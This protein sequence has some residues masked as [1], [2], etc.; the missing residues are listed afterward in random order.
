MTSRLRGLCTA[1][2]F[3]TVSFAQAP[4]IQAPGGGSIQLDTSPGDRVKVTT[5]Y[6]HLEFDLRNGG[7][8]DT[9]VFKHGSGNNLLLAP[10]RTYVDRWCAA[11]APKT[12]FRP[13]RN[14]DIVTLEFSGRMA[15]AGR[16]P[17]PVEF[18]TTWTLSP[19]V[20]RADYKLRFLEDAM[21]S[22][23]GVVSTSLRRELNEWGLRVG[24]T[25]DPDRRK[26][27]GGRF[28]KVQQAG[29]VLIAEHH[30]PTYM[31][32]FDRAKEGFDITVA[33]DVA[34]WETGLA[35]R[36]GVGR[37][38]AK[39]ADDGGSISLAME[40]LSLPYP[41]KVAKGE[42][43]FSYYLGLPRIVEKAN[44][45]W[46]HLSF[47]NHPWPSDTEVKKWAD[48][49]VNIVRLHNDYAEDENFWH[50][51]AWPPYDDK[52]M[53]EMKRVI[54]ACHRHNIQVVPYFSIHE[55]HP[56][57][58]GY[59]ANENEW[60]R[61]VDQAG[62][63]FHNAW[64]KGEFGAQMCPQSRWLERRKQDI[65]RAYRDLGFDGIYYDWVMTLPCTNKAHNEKLHLG[66]DGVID[67]LAWTRRLVAPNGTLILHLYG[68]MP[69]IAFENFADLVVNMEEISGA[70]KLMVMDEVPIVTVLAESIMRSPCPSY[71]RDMPVERNQRNIAHLVVLG[72]F[73][74]SGGTGDGVYA[75]TLKLFRTF[76]PYRLEDYRFHDA[77]T[78][79]V[80]TSWETVYGALYS[81][82]EQAVVIVSNARPEKR[83]NVVWRVEAEDLGMSPAAKLTVKDV[84]TGQT[85]Q[86]APAAL[87]DGSFMTELDG[88]EYRLFEIAPAK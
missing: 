20:A 14:G 53:A 66:T 50:D 51:G 54:A 16:N 27:A 11:N 5:D 62:T 23:A 80:K 56:K 68:A 36:G 8:L 43:T 38:E 41:V 88:Y 46:M 71:R 76:K 24:M 3:C 75:E 74:W 58:E 65:E 35:K 55:F 70:E 34:T 57:A 61:S 52:G 40:P 13:S 18:V 26:M 37:Y 33:S 45:K 82:P 60:K 72:M 6:W 79:V 84:K 28:G 42:Y 73:P 31:L 67:L 83:K 64:G 9:I 81:S 25:D 39:V 15:A 48:N 59:A 69:S 32:F 86:V 1:A 10:F 78:G 7:A 85:Q 49:G 29:E 12:D 21:V 30:A 77:L 87:S 2:L 19:F 63:V 22:K 17:G 44:R 47:G 4:Q